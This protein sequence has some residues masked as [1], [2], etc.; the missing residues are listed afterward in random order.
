MAPSGI[1]G[2][3]IEGCIWLLPIYILFYWA[4]LGILWTYSN[5][6]ALPPP[7]PPR[8]DLQPLGDPQLGNAPPPPG[9]PQLGNA[10]PPPGDPQ[11]GNAPPPPGDQQ[12][13]NA[14]PPPGDQ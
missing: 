11:L 10:P 1:G 5:C 9:D 6:H 2:N 4:V 13:G 12:L 3:T 14:P 8:N 7:P